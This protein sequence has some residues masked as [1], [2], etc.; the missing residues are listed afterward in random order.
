[1]VVISW[2]TAVWLIGGVC[3]VEKYRPDTFEDVSGHH[4]ILATIN[5]FVEC[6]VCLLLVL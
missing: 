1:M 4:D 5:K 3:R 6:N 2:E